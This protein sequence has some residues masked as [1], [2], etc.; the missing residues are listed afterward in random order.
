MT[1][2]SRPKNPA[3]TKTKRNYPINL[4]AVLTAVMALTLFLVKPVLADTVL[5][6]DESFQ[7]VLS[8]GIRLGTNDSGAVNTSIR[9]GNDPSLSNNGNLTWN[10]SSKTFNLDHT[11]TVTG[12]FSATGNANFSGA[13]EFHIREVVSTSTASCTTVGELVLDK[14]NNKIYTCSVAG[15]PGTWIT[16]TSSASD[17]EGVYGADAGKDLTT[18]NGAFS[19]NTG[20]NNFAVDSNLWNV[21]SAGF[22]DAAKVTSNGLLTGSQGANISGG[23]VNFNASS[24]FVTNINTGTSTGQINLGGGSNCVKVDSNTWDVSCA[25]AMTSLTGI[26]SNGPI[27]FTQATV[28]LI[29][30]LAS[31]PLTCVP[32]QQYYNTTTNTVRLCVTDGVWTGNGPSGTQYFFAYDTTSQTVASAGAFQ[33]ILFSTNAQIDG[34]NHNPGST[35]FVSTVTGTF[36]ANVTARV[37]KNGGAN[38]TISMRMTKN[39]VEVP[40]SQSYGTCAGSTGDTMSGNFIFQVAAGDIIRIQMTGGT[41]NVQ[42]L[43]GGAGTV[44]PS[45]QFNVWRMK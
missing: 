9:F 15:T 6:Q 25:G 41:S 22:L 30:Q 24:N 42:I 17:F 18:G 43:P 39:G 28:F 8:D 13:S 20:T 26:T 11:T 35:D 33:N 27:D 16:T 45:I 36:M 3:H 19:I 31:D 32:G 40:G 4:A 7:E 5:F 2:F 14:G 21:T 23:I 38:T 12:G 10:I 34:W 1:K 37:A 29:A 44:Q